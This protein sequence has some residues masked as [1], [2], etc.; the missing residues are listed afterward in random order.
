MNVEQWMRKQDGIEALQK[1][2]VL[3]LEED[4]VSVLMDRDSARGRYMAI[5]IDGSTA[6]LLCPVLKVHALY[7]LI[8]QAYEGE[9]PA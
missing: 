2:A 3:E 6:R 7:R 1:E 5:G 8:R 9:E 4:G